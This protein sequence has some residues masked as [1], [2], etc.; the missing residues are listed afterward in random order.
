M[1]SRP[2]D[3]SIVYCTEKDSSSS[4]G[5]IKIFSI[6]LVLE[7]RERGFCRTLEKIDTNYILP[8]FVLF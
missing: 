4:F 7:E 3:I 1:T 2:F 6:C 8:S 5:K